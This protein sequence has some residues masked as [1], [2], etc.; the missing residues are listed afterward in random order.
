MR[1]YREG[2]P[3]EQT[4]AHMKETVNNKK[5]PSDANLNKKRPSS[6]FSDDEEWDPAALDWAFLDAGGTVDETVATDAGDEENAP[7]H[8]PAASSSA[9]DQGLLLFAHQ[10]IL[11]WYIGILFVGSSFNHYLLFL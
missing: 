9:V 2:T 8:D 7:V 5:L 11:C 3:A 1:S 10:C 4:K 6:G